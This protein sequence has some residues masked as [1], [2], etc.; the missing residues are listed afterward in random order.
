L[1]KALLFAAMMLVS[2]LAMA[3]ES[4]VVAVISDGPSDR[5]GDQ[6][7][8]FVEELLALTGREFNV[9]IKEYSGNWARDE[10]LAA[11]D[12]AYADDSVDYV[13][14]TGFV[15]NQLAATRL[16]FPKP[17][18]LPAI[19][20]TGLLK[21]AP[22]DGHSGIRNLNYLAAYADFGEDLDTLASITSYDSLVLFL[23]ENLASAI[24]ELRSAALDVAD[25]RGIELFQVTHDGVNHELINDVPEGTDAI[26]V[27]ALPRMPA[28]KF[29]EL[30]NAIN[31]AGIPSY[32]FAA[33]ADVER[34]LLAT[35][36]EP[37]DIDRQARLNALNM[38]AVMLGEA[39][40]DQ[41]VA[42]S[43]KDKLT[44]NMATARMIGLSPSFDI[45]NEAVLL[46]QD[47]QIHGQVFNLVDIAETALL[48]NQDLQAAQFGVLAS[49]N[50]VNRAR[51]AMFPQ[52]G[53]SGSYTTRNDSPSVTLG[54]FP[55]QSTDA[56][57]SLDQLI[58]SDSV[59][60]GVT[61]QKELQRNRE[62]ELQKL[63]LD[64]VQAATTAYYLVLNAR[65]QLRVQENN[66]RI[67]RTN[68]ELA[69]NRVTL[70][71]S[72][73]ADVYRWEAEVARAQVVVVSARS[74]LRQSWETLNRIL[75]REQ[76]TRVVLNEAVFD[77][78][79]IMSRAEFDDLVRSPA[80]YAKFSMFYIERALRQ[81]PELDQINAQIAAKERELSSAKRA[82]WLPDFTIGGRYTD[83]LNQSGIGAGPTAGQGLTD[84][85]VGVQATLPIFSGG[86]KKANASRAEFEL[87]QLQASRI[88]TEERVEEEVRIQLHAAQAA[89]AQ[90]DLT[91]AAAESSRKNFELVS[92]AYARGTV[93][94]IELLDAQDTSLEASAAA[95]ASL[96]NFL[97]TIMS[98]Q[99]AVGGYDYLLSPEERG[100]LA[101]QFRAVL[102]EESP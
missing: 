54:L 19:L 13:L 65:S 11:I 58:Y 101:V 40:E 90:I 27:A 69:Q 72:T 47:A 4:I 57:I 3:Q 44:I 20:D 99:R 12:A 2:T 97:I 22:V 98:L 28:Q 34:G 60:A 51:S 10:M 25:S 68:L 100:E 38:Q 70:G 86:L 81:A 89:Y 1:K 80:D 92:D 42:S 17:T 31:A 30:V 91:A 73:L 52:V 75:H 18:F 71:T 95:E 56:A 102:A 5:M 62:A 24:P 67:S 43:V 85:S 63:R 94:V 39:P 35:N 50:E 29:Q 48:M 41:P 9:Q 61:I 16:E 82:Y 21:N 23:D 93:N 87:R 46:N 36:T 78:P 45:L 76:G 88:G 84:W 59:A 83:N 6:Q 66:L 96:Y 15:S 77:E 14:V 64:V 26:F 79:F 8:R 53:L 7:Q 32:S 55:E 49:A 33:V 74:D 37:R